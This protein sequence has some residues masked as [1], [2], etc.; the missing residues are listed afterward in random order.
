MFTSISKLV[1][2]ASPKNQ[3]AK[4][5]REELQGKI[6]TLHASQAS[7]ISSADKASSF[8][9]RKGAGALNERNLNA[10]MSA[11]AS[12]LAA[13]KRTKA[14]EK[15]KPASR[16]NKV[17]IEEEEQQEQ[18]KPKPRAARKVVRRKLVQSD[19]DESE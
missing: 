1:S 2:K 12:E 9:K 6:Q 16:K 15:K 8:S 3:D 7:D 17:V 18:V 11:G 5:A 19:E 10:L 13:T 4:R 14:A